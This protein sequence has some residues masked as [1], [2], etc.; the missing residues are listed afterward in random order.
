MLQKDNAI[1]SSSKLTEQFSPLLAL[2]AYLWPDVRFYDKQV[3]IILSVEQ[4]K[5]TYVPAG[6]MLGKDFVA[7]FIALGS[8]ILHKK[9]RIVTTS[10]K[11][12][13]LRVL[14]GEIGNFARTAKY[15]LDL[16]NGG[17]L[18]FK[19]R[20]INKFRDGQYCEISYLK[21]MVSE[22]GEGLAG[23]HAPYNLFIGDE[24]SGLDDQVMRVGA[25]TW[26]KKYLLIGNP[27]PCTNFFFKEVMGGDLK[28]ESNGHYVRKV[29]KIKAEDS[30]NVT[31]GAELERQTGRVED[32][33]IVPGVLDY[34]E[35]KYRRK[36]W[37]PI[38]QCVGL[39]GEFYQGAEVLFYSP[40]WRSLSMRRAKEIRSRDRIPKAIG[41]D[42]AEGGDKSCFSVVDEHGLI[43]QES[44]STPDTTVIT[45]R[46]IA[47]INEYGVEPDSVVFD[48]GGGGKQHA[49]VLRRKGYNVR[50]VGFGEKADDEKYIR[51]VRSVKEKKEEAET[52]YVY[53][54]RRGQMFHELRIMMDP[55]GNENVFALPEEYEELQR[56]MAPIPLEYDG[57]GR[58]WLPPKRKL[59]PKS[60]VQTLVELIG[61]S[62]DELDSLVLAIFG[63]TH[64]SVIP[65]RLGVLV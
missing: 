10:V 62:P 53:L 17:T 44:I 23:H 19:H 8:F 21:G 54:N 25:E 30:P 64:K 58:I 11:D 28:A 1:L 39:D 22:K 60:T 59:N 51:R 38:R 15:P 29:I 4:N 32:A 20:E 57:E 27:L 36:H 46:T 48:R 43:Y 9:A 24:A 63:M 16:K 2:A 31:A 40:Q 6:N 49:D 55:S 56:Q 61:H 7:G 18:I 41:I 5:K 37:D 35:Y 12:D 52:K 13:H 42:P 3:E 45:N 34:E 33:R 47:L 65:K 26:A 14:W 50:T